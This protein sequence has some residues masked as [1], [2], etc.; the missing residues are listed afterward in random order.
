MWCYQQKECFYYREEWAEYTDWF[1]QRNGRNELNLNQFKL[2]N[3]QSNGFTLRFFHCY[4]AIFP[5]KSKFAI[6]KL[7]W[8]LFS[9]IF[10]LLEQ[11][12]MQVVFN[13]ILVNCSL[14]KIFIEHLIFR[15]HTLNMNL[16]SSCTFGTV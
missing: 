5:L 3:S 6:S 8:N 14:I 7:E 2:F 9:T 16:R 15:L 4:I 10:F 1:L 13:Y 12:H 11:C